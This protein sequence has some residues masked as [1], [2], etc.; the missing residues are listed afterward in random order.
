VFLK[1]LLVALVLPP[2]G[3]LSLTVLGLLQLPTMPRVAR[4]LLWIGVL[5]LLASAMPTVSDT[6]LVALETGLD[7]TPP[8]NDPPQAIVILGAEII[9]TGGTSPGIQ[10]GRL[11]LERLRAGAE[12]QR[13]TGLPVLVTGGTT[14]KH[15]PPVGT[16][17]AHSMTE[18]FRVPVRWTETESRDTWENATDSAAILRAAGIHSV[19]V[20]THSWHMRRALDAFARTGLIATPAPT[21][22]NRSTSPGWQDLLPRVSAWQSSYYAMHEWVGRA[23]YAL[24]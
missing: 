6:M 21:P 15:E 4:G 1:E 19:Y 20:V 17:M 24:R 12:L 13:R 16:V 3:F 7:T 5:G 10:V 22:L 2:F 14:Q 11:T 8:P 23:W 18:D 9:R